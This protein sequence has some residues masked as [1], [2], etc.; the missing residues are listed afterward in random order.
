[1]PNAHLEFEVAA[2]IH[3]VWGFVKDIGNWASQMPGYQKVEV[4]SEDASVWTA[5]V[6]I[7]PFSQIVTAAVH[8]TKWQCPDEVQFEFQGRSDPFRGSG[9]YK[10]EARDRRTLIRL[11]LAVEGSGPVAGMLNALA[12]PALRKVGSQFADNLKNAIEARLAPNLG[13]QP[14]TQVR[15]APLSERL[16][17]WLHTIKRKIMAQ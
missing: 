6:D 8:V 2:A 5:K 1:M 17:E 12:G 3:D 7:G 14:S 9:S 11:D 10:S 15:K 16:R 13:S 4:L